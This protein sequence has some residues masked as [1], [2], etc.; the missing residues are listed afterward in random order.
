MKYIKICENCGKEFQTN[1]ENQKYCN[2]YCA[3]RARH[4]RQEEKSSLY[5]SYKT[6]QENEQQ[7]EITPIN[8]SG[9]QEF[10]G[11]EIPVIEGGFGEGQKIML[12]KTIAEIHGQSIDKVNELINNHLEEFEIGIDIINLKGNEEFET[13]CKGNGIYTQNA[14]NKAKYIYLL[15]EQG[16]MLLVGFMKTNRAKEIR[17][18]LRREYFTMRQ[19]INQ[20]SKDEKAWIELKRANQDENAQYL[21]DHA[22]E[23]II[24]AYTGILKEAM[25]GEG[26][27]ITL[28][29][30]AKSLEEA[31]EMEVKTIDISDFLFSK[32]YLVKRFFQRINN[33]TGELSYRRDP[34]GL[35]YPE[36]TRTPWMEK[37]AHKQPTNKF[38]DEFANKG[39][40]LTKDPDARGKIMW[41]FTDR[42]ENYFKQNFL[43][44]FI[45]FIQNKKGWK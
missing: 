2:Q 33:N 3:G 6:M 20:L 10:M 40:A 32:G 8:I 45:Y 13:L 28:S 7:S 17:K 39:L 43:K 41:E 4:K 30:L 38:M 27:K 29:Q 34:R 21:I 16:Y 12:A 25:D 9:N 19:V 18:Q 15:S 37:Q 1:R 5:S 44:E 22:I 23:E 24:G 36:E 26:R 11:I 14:I 35:L 31:I 42:F